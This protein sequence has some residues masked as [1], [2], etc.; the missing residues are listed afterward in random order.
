MPGGRVPRRPASKGSMQIAAYLGSNA[1]ATLN[2]TCRVAR[3][4][5]CDQRHLLANHTQIRDPEVTQLATCFW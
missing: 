1:P 2:F 4:L 5:A 3:A